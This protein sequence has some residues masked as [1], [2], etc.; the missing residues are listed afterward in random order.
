MIIKVHGLSMGDSMVIKT[1]EI[2]A[3]MVNYNK[4]KYDNNII[5]NSISKPS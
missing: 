5:R 1:D 2:K 3:G 4:T